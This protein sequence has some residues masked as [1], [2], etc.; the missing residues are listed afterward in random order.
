MGELRDILSSGDIDEIVLDG[1]KTVWHSGNFTPPPTPIDR[2]FDYE[3]VE[4]IDVT[5][6]D[7]DWTD[8]ITLT[9]PSREA[10]TYALSF[11]LQFHLNSTSQAFLY[12]FSLDG[13]ATWGL[14]YEKEVKDRHNTEVIEVFDI[15]ELGADAVIDLRVQVTREADAACQVIKA[16]IACERKA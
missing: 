13:G 14:D 8:L 6:T 9:T 12:R 15:L 7:P 2:T 5:T 4:A 1:D 11:S 3:I 16:I 10:G